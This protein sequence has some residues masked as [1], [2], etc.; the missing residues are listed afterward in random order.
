MID[1]EAVRQYSVPTLETRPALFASRSSCEKQAAP[2][3]LC[4]ECNGGKNNKD[5]TN[6]HEPKPQVHPPSTVW[7]ARFFDLRRHNRENS[8]SSKTLLTRRGARS[9]DAA[10]RGLHRGQT[11]TCTSSTLGQPG[12]RHFAC[13][14]SKTT[15]A[16]A[17]S[18]ARSS[19]C[20]GARCVPVSSQTTCC[21]RSRASV[22]RLA[23][24][25]PKIRGA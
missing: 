3:T 16:R 21:K 15:S 18:L 7:S 10:L 13:L 8:S 9:M 11:R 14:L 5:D 20:S 22:R 19:G 23:T 12:I 24:A 6:F 4:L 25:G 17:S 2:R 1:D